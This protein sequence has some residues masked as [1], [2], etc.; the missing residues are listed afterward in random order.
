METGSPAPLGATPDDNG[1]NFAVYSSVAE[2]VELCLYSKRGKPERSYRLPGCTDGVRHGYLP[3][4]Q[5]GQRYGYR[6]HGPWQP[7]AG[8][9]CN[10]NKLLVDPYCRELDGT[11]TW[12]EAVFDY[13]PGADALTMSPL[14]SAGHVPL[15]VGCSPLDT[16]LD[17]RPSVPWSETVIYETNLRGYT[18]RHPEVP[19]AD[20]GTF[21]GM[22]NGAVLDYLRSLGVTSVELLPVQAY[23][24]EH[25]LAKRGLRNFWGYNTIAFFAPM[26]RF[27]AGEARRDFVDMVN[28][29]HGAGMEVILDIAFNHTGESDGSGPT[30]CFRGLDNQAYYRLEPGD[31]AAYIN[32]TGTGNTLN[33]DHPRAQALVLDCLRYW[34]G[35]LGVDG[36]RF[37]LA[38]ILGRHAHGFSAQHPLLAAISA[39][40]RLQD[41]KLIAEPW[42]PGPGGYQLGQFPDRWAEWNDKYRDTARRFWRGDAGMN[43]EFARRLHGSADIFDHR[44]R[45]P[46]AS[47]NFVTSHD[48]FTLADVVGYKRRHNEANGEQNRDGHAHNYSCNHGVEGD[49]D[50][51]DILAVRRRHRLNLLASLLLSQGTPMLLAGDEFGNSQGGNN[52]AYAQD[53]ETGWL[54]W[55]GLEY[56]P[57]FMLEVRELIHLRKEWPLLR[58]P[59]YLHG[60]AEIGSSIVHIDWLNA[61]GK[62][63]NEHDWSGP[64]PFKVMLAESSTD[65]AKSQAAV[66]FNNRNEAIEFRL[67]NGTP[68]KPWRV[69]WSAD[70]ASVADDGCSFT[71]RARSI[72]F[73]VSGAG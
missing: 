73:L 54:D 4:C 47:V 31:P 36:F 37:D 64:A 44:G 34:S 46:F 65:G 69:A 72:T 71:A 16:I 35:E 66:L 12:H 62:P 45:A 2:S 5:P 67:P 61:E 23:I 21:A 49:T 51:A 60:E 68:G 15:S 56:D 29:I 6:V 43:G 25:H 42:D 59:E 14:D 57:E 22:Q 9:R 11:F 70:E 18:M 48:G 55:S 13:L 10:P 39:D 58:L 28:A 53:N 3:G 19:E 40:P 38:T 1:V 20:R 32:D 17:E 50:N 8:L 41:V 26:P 33:A 7:D 24:D 52:N 27:A 63:M 30:L